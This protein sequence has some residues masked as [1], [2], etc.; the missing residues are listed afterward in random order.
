VNRALHRCSARSH[1]KGAAGLILLA[2]LVLPAFSTGAAESNPAPPDATAATPDLSDLSLEDL[3]HVKVASVY[4]ASKHEQILAEAPSSVTIVTSDEIKKSGYR[5]LTEILNSVRGFYT[6]DDRAYSYIGLRGFNR[7]GDY[8]GRILVMVDGHRLNDAI[9]DSAFNGTEFLLDV[10]LIDRVEVI[11]G[12]GSSLYGNN[13]FFGVINVITRRGSDLN[14]GEASGSYASYDTYTGRLS[15]GKRFQNGLEF[16][17]SGSYFDSVGHESLFYQEF[18]RINNGYAIDLDGSRTASGFASVSYGEISLEGGVVQRK[19]SLPTAAYGTVFNQGPNDVLDE[20]AFADLK[21]Q[22]E[23]SHAFELS[24]R[25][26]YDHYHYEG[27]APYAQYDLVDPRYPGLLTFNRDVSIQE[28]L[29]TELQ[30]TKT[31]CEKHRLTAGVE[32]RHDFKLDLD[33]FDI[34]PPVNYVHANLD[35]DTVG[36]YAQDEYTILH[37]LLLNAGV[38]YDYFSS[39]GDTINPRAALIYSP[40]TNSTFKVLYGQAFRAPNAYELYYQAP[41]YMANPELKPE[42]IHS[43]ELVYEQ[44]I[45]P[46]LRLTTSLFYNQIDDL[47]SFGTDSTGTNSIFGN[48]DGAVSRGGEL[49][50]DANWGKGW[51]ARASYTYADAYDSGTGR[52]LSNSPEH[53]GKFMLTAPVW[54]Q[55]IFATVELLALS[56]RETV[57]NN[58]AN[59]YWLVN[60]TLFSREIV[61]GLDLSASVYNLLD[62]RYGD[63]VSSDFPQDTIEQNGRTFRVKLTYHF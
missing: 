35:A 19:K 7:P 42:T 43:T 27:T 49:E 18:S 51:Q 44:V 29:G 11:R 33:N 22:H 16:A 41:G 20:R 45:I 46:Q 32:Y 62:E 50:L 56:D 2:I 52:R 40:W 23:F 39:F 34:D 21:F 9:Y 28:S 3:G 26:Y 54:R 12:P 10:D 24:T 6:T 36:V 55:K 47:I 38:R 15:Y 58:T 37:N 53:V 63:P 17:L 25:L 30:L 14:G 4:G 1:R 5:T 57:H 31:L 60:L 48:L 61:K 59:G 8:G 13:A